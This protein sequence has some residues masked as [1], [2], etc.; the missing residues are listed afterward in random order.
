MGSASARTYVTRGTDILVCTAQGRRF[1]V[2]SLARPYRRLPAGVF[3]HE[4]ALRAE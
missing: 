1:Q 2:A 4:V 3:E